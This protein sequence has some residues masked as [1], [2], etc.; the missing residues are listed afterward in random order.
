MKKKDAI[1]YYGRVANID[2][3]IRILSAQI[4]QMIIF[5]SILTGTDFILQ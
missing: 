1:E 2:S 3:A 5:I 4:E